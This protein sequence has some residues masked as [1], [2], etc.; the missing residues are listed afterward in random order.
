MRFQVRALLKRSLLPPPAGTDLEECEERWHCAGP[1]PRKAG[2]CISHQRLAGE[3]D[4]G[5]RLV[6]PVLDDESHLRTMTFT[7]Q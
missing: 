7:Q 6:G 3:G 5:V 2:F 4:H 1:W